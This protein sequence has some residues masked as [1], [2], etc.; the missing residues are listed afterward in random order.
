MHCLFTNSVVSQET[1]LFYFL[2]T[3]GFP[4]FVILIIY[5]ESSFHIIKR[6]VFVFK[7]LLLLIVVK[8]QSIHDTE[9]C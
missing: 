6:Q 1:P 4:I 2:V 3:F 5:K 7:V 9:F 8:W